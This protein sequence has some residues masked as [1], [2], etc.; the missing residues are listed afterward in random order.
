M[1]CY[2]SLEKIPALRGPVH[3][4][5]GMFDGVHLGHKE[6]IG[7]SVASAAQAGGTSGVL[8]F[9]PHPSRLF[10]PENPVPQILSREDKDERIARL[11]PGFI[12]HQPFTREFAAQAAKGFLESLRNAIPNLFAIHVGKNF[13]F[14]KNRTGD[15]AWLVEHA[16]R[17][18]LHVLSANDIQA[19][20]ERISSTRIRGLITEGEMAVANA[21][22]GYNYAVHG[23]VI[24]GRALGRT[25]GFPTLNIPWMPE[26]KPRQG[27]YAVRAKTKGSDW[28]SGVANY[29]QRP[30]VENGP[31]SPLLEVHLLSGGDDVR[32]AGFGPGAMMEVELLEFIRPEKKFKG[33][34]ELRAQIAKDTTAARRFFETGMM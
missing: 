13:R 14:G 3:L 15:V 31:V 30:T 7:G 32:R 9:T 34:D 11:G 16:N 22:L 20:G 10:H 5:V 23:E 17:L 33:L 26:L 25:L 18:G 24:G 1:K 8:T 2:E 6:V 4:A 28:F 21:L 19:D 29:G 12:V 27:V